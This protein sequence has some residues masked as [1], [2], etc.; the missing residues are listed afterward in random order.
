MDEDTQAVSRSVQAGGETY[1]IGKFKGYKAF[2]IGRQLTALGEIGPKVSEA[3]NK[4][5]T[6]YRKQNVDTIPRATLEFRYPADAANVSEEAWKESGGVIELSSEPSQAEVMAVVLPTLFDLA[7]DAIFDLLAWV[8]AD[9]AELERL[10]NEG[11]EAIKT[12]IA[13]LRKKLMF[14]A[15]VDQL[16]ELA[17]AAQGVLADQLAGK[18]DQ[19]RSLLKLVGLDQNPDEEE[20][21]EEASTT[22]E[23]G[24]TAASPEFEPESKDETLSTPESETTR[25]R[26]DSSTDSPLPTDGDEETSSM[27]RAG[28]PSLSTSG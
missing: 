8:V 1:T 14:G 13:G 11:E 18:A 3:L 21:E 16:L 24:R 26:P 23:D 20:P 22:T 5:S 2:R 17:T 12:Y 7:G 6:E 15:D 10:D 28:E 9:D 19:A 4:F 25:P 27:A